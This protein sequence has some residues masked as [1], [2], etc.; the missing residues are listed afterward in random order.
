MELFPYPLSDAA[1]LVATAREDSGLS[2]SA[3]A[4]AAGV[5]QAAISR[6]EAGSLIPS[7]ELLTLILRAAEL[8]PSVPLE[9]YADRI[10]S[11]ALRHGIDTVAVFGSTVSGRDT[12]DSDAD[13]L[14]TPGDATGI[15]DID[16]FGAEAAQILGFPVDVVSSRSR[17]AAA[18]EARRTA[19]AL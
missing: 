17:G 15:F 3:L 5:S 8:R 6:I 7:R 9:K 1:D 12:A 2:Q 14:I 13:L 10:R 4:R 16:L 19:V 18:D 11:A